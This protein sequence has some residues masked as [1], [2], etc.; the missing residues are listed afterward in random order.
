MISQ[1]RC[2]AKLHGIFKQAQR[3]SID[4]RFLLLV[5]GYDRLVGN[6]I[7]RLSSCGVVILRESI[8][9]ST[10]HCLQCVAWLDRAW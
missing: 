2:R 5:G 6:Q 4:G 7:A 8:L 3:Q 1:P 9:I 10:L